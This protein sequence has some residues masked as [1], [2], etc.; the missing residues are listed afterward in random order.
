MFSAL[1]L[2]PLSNS[3]VAYC[4]VFSGG[5]SLGP[6]PV[7]SASLFGSCSVHL[8]IQS[9]VTFIKEVGEIIASLEE[10]IKFINEV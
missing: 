6:H 10:L 3:S 4:R 2:S 8:I 1:D 9:L 7:R 5:S